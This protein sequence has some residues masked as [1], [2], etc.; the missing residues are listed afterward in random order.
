MTTFSVFEE[1]KFLQ[2]YLEESITP[3]LEK[4][5]TIEGLWERT[6]DY[7]EVD[8]HRTQALKNLTTLTADKQELT[9]A[10][11]SP[12]LCCQ[13][14]NSLRS[15][16]GAQAGYIPTGKVDNLTFIIPNSGLA[17]RIQRW[18]MYSRNEINYLQIKGDHYSIFK[19]DSSD[20]LH[21]LQK[22]LEQND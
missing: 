9:A 18:Q 17:K 5:T 3:A 19:Q 10:K 1:R 15:L 2:S 14:I 7:L 16:L 11:I 4:E 21:V 12:E 8:A 6:R 13:Y 22:L 20:L